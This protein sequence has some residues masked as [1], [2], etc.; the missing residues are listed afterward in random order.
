MRDL[1]S[2]TVTANVETLRQY[3]SFF[4]IFNL[5]SFT[6]FGLKHKNFISLEA[7]TFGKLVVSL[8]Q[9]YSFPKVSTEFDSFSSNFSLLRFR[10]CPITVLLKTEIAG[11]F[12]KIY[13]FSN[14]TL[15]QQLS[16]QRTLN[17]VPIL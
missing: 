14:K 4:L 8:R 11:R 3:K 9:G 7:F 12:R 16:S 1:L 5:I 17:L 13:R 15:P 6:A 10:S 2:Q